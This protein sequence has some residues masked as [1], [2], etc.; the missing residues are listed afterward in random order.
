MHGLEKIIENKDKHIE[1]L[2]KNNKN[3]N[4]L[5]LK[6]KLATLESTLNSKE[7]IMYELNDKYERMNKEIITLKNERND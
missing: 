1:L 4:N 5:L 3:D 7:N 6:N 2:E